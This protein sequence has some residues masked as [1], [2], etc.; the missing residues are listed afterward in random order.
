MKRIKPIIKNIIIIRWIILVVQALKTVGRYEIFYLW[1]IAGIPF[2][3]RKMC[4][5]L[6]P[7]NYDIAGSLGIIFLNFLLGGVIG[8]IALII[9]FIKNVIEIFKI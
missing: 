4:M 7:K 2:G 3:M 8:G 1:I 6:I 5:I 9:T